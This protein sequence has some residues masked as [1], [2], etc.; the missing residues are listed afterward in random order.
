MKCE[1]ASPENKR[2][3]REAFSSVGT[4][5][6]DPWRQ[7]LTVQ[8]LFHLVPYPL[9]LLSTKFNFCFLFCGALVQCERE[10]SYIGLLRSSPSLANHVVVS[11]ML[12][13]N[14]RNCSPLFQLLPHFSS[15]LRQNVMFA[16]L[17]ALLQNLLSS[18]FI[19]NTSLFLKMWLGPNFL[20]LYFHLRNC[21]LDKCK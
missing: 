8:F 9:V 19:Y 20:K 10:P 2:Q 6:V 13:C 16:S 18:M 1:L 11:P 4:V 21:Y 15:I 3:K 17:F 5:Q 7:K 12:D 14:G